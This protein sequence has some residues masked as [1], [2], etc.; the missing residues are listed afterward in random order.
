MS[1]W[2]KSSVLSGEVT[3]AELAAILAADGVVC[4]VDRNRLLEISERG[5]IAPIVSLPV[6]V[7]EEVTEAERGDVE[8]GRAVTEGSSSPR[9]RD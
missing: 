4:R 6:L 9:V 8:E 7:E 3:A 2:L 1:G 5:L